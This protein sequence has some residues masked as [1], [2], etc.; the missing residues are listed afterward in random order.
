MASGL[1]SGPRAKRLALAV[2]AAALLL[3]ASA[4][5]R[6]FDTVAGFVQACQRM[7]AAGNKNDLTLEQL[8]ETGQMRGYVDA[9]LDSIQELYHDICLPEMSLTQVC[10]AVVNWYGTHQNYARSTPYAGLVAALRQF[11]PC[12]PPP[13]PTP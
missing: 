3:P 7:D 5:A 13:V 6:S 1:T 11:Y 2:A 4:G 9:T 8:A 12:P 10:A